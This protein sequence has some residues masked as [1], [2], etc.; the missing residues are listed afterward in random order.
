M[1]AARGVGYMDVPNESIYRLLIKSGRLH[2][3]MSPLFFIVRKLP[4]GYL[5]SRDQKRVGIKQAKLLI[6]KIFL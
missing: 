6:L 5:L 2:I 4:S 3:F 1:V